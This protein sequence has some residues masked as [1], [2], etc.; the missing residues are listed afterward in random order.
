MSFY[1]STHPMRTIIRAQSISLVGKYLALFRAEP[2]FARLLIAGFVSG[3]G[4]QFNR[5]AILTLILAVIGSPQAV[6]ITLA[7]S[8]GVHLILS[9]FA[10]LLADRLPRKA[11]L[12]VSDVI[13]S[14]IALSFILVMATRALSVVYVGTVLLA[15][16]SAIFEP[17]RVASTAVLVNKKNL[18]AANALEQVVSGSIMIIGS[19]AG[20]L[21][22]VGLGLAASFIVNS[23][24]FLASALL[25]S[26]IDFPAFNDDESRQRGIGVAI[27]LIVQSQALKALVILFAVWPLAG[28]IMN[29]LISV[30]AFK[31]FHAGAFG[32][33]LLYTAL[34][35]GFVL[36]GIVGVWLGGNE[37]WSTPLA[38][39]LEGVA[40]MVVSM[41]PN[42]GSAAGLLCLATVFA[43]IGNASA[44]ALLMMHVTQQMLGRV[45][46]LLEVVSALG[47]IVSMSLAALLLSITTPRTLGFG[48]GAMLSLSGLAVGGAL[49]RSRVGERRRQRHAEGV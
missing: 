17:A 32:I 31:V 3:V 16:F 14:A 9:P 39:A 27:T 46:G 30:Y 15:F 48:A 43:S 18:V 33:G 42:L 6:G 7:I 26:S 45:Y 35:V 22:V 24:S 23:A 37:W 8:V 5:V 36:G 10:G 40:Y 38:F 29:V 49:W 2:A 25:I 44:G 11:I 1:G 20:G 12:V 34:G 47:F 28:G 13:R 19:L 21:S 41:M 4:D